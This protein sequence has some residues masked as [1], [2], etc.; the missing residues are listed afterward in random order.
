MDLIFNNNFESLTRKL[1]DLHFEYNH[2]IILIFI[3]FLS[4]FMQGVSSRE[5]IL[6]D[7]RSLGDYLF[8]QKENEPDYNLKLFI[9]D[10]MIFTQIN[11]DG[12]IQAL[13]D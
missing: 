12:L 6:S 4:D 11:V 7:L 10:I 1:E 9:A 13:F 2:D 5:R 3:D 8:L